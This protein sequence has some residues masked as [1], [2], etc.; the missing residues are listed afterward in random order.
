MR[1]NCLK[2][3][4]KAAVLLAAVLLL[5][6]GITAAQSV[7]L[8]AGPATATLPDGSAVPMWGYTCGAVVAP[9]TCSPLNPAS[10]GWSPVV[11]TVPTGTSLAINLTN[12]LS[13]AG[14]NIPTSLTIV[15][16]VGGGLGTGAVAV[17]SPEHPSQQTTWPLVNA[18]P[19]WIPPA[20]GPRVQSFA[21]EVAVGTPQTLTWTN[22]RPGT[23]LI[24]SGT[25]P[26][27][28]GPMGL[29]GILVVTQVPVGTTAGT[30]Y[31]AVGSTPAVNYNAE[32]PLL[33][34]EIDPA[35]NN[36]VNAA[37]KTVGFSEN[38]S[39][40]PQVSGVVLGVSVTNPGSGYTSA[41]NVTLVGGGGSG[42]TATA[43]IDAVLTSPTYGQVTSI[44]VTSGG[45]N[46]TSPPTVV[47]T[48]T[49]GG[50]GA[51]A[52]S[53]L[54][55]SSNSLASCMTQAGPVAA[56]YPPAVNYTPLYYMVNGVA[57]NKTIASAS[58]FPVSP[59]TGVALTGNVL[60]RMV[61][62][63]VRMHVP[64]IVGS[65]AQQ[66][67]TGT[68][69]TVGGFQLI[70]EDGN[71][72]PGIPRVQ[73][74]V[75]MAPGKTYDVKINV[76]AATA[77]A[78]PIYDRELSL[79]G[80]ATERDAGMLAYISVNG[81]GL[82]VPATA[83]AVANADTYN[84]L[85]AGQTFTVSDTGKG[86][87]AND[88]NVYAVQVKTPP[89]NGT[90]TL[91][92]NGTFT[93]VPTGTATTDSFVYEANG[94]PAIFATVTLGPA[95]IEAASGITVSANCTVPLTYTSKL[96]TFI[97]V[98]PPGILSCFND[99]AGYPL[100]A[101]SVTPG[102]GL[103][104]TTLNVDKNGGFSASVSGAGTYSFTFVPQNSQGT[105]AAAATTV[106]V[107]FPT[108]NGPTVQ[109]VD[110][111]SGAPITDYRWIIEEDRTFY[112]SPNC[113]SN[114][115][116][117]GCIQT[118]AGTVP[119]LG[120]NFHTSDMP[121]VAQGCTGT[122][123]CE[124]GQTLLGQPA[125]C[126]VGNGSC[127]TTGTQKAAVD[128]SQVALDPSKRYYISVLPGDAAQPFISGNQTASCLPA[129]GGVSPNCGHSMG[130]API[131]VACTPAVGSTTCTGTFP[132]VKVLVEQ[133]PFPPAKLAVNVFEDDFPL[134]GEQDSGGGIDVL[135]TNEP[136][137]GQFNILLWDDMGGS[138]DVTG[139]MTYDMF[140]MPLSNSLDGYIDPA[141]GQN[142]CPIS[143]AGQGI[144]GMIVTCP[145]FESDGVTL[146]PLAGE[147][148]IANLMP[149]RFSV[150]A[151]PGA[152]RIARGEEWL[153]TNTLDG[154]KAHDSFLRIGEPDYFQEFGPA[155]YHVNIGFANPKIINGRLAGVCAG[156]DQNLSL[157][158]GSSCN[159]TL[160][161]KV[162][163]ERMS[164]TPD[165]RLYSSGSRDS[166]YFTQCFVSVGDPDGED[167][168]FTKCAADGTFTL[169]G[170]PPG[171]WR[172][173]TFD[174]WNDQIVDGLSFPVG[175]NAGASGGGSNVGNG[176]CPGA[177]TSAN[178]C[179][180]GDVPA[181]QWQA[182][183][184]TKTFIDIPKTGV[185]NADVDEGI[186]FAS[187][188][189][190]YRDGSM[191]NNLTTDFTG[192]ANFNEE[193]PLFN[194][195]TV[196]TDVTRYKNTGIHTVYDSGGPAD[197]TTSCGQKTSGY[198]NCGT[199]T[200]YNFLANTNEPVPLPGDLSVPGAIYCTTADCAS[201]SIL[202]GAKPSRAGISTGRVD[203]PWVGVEGWQGYSGENNFIEFGKAP[204]T[205][206]ENGGIKGHVIYAS[207]RPF[208]DP[209]MLVQTQWEPL[210]PH[211]TMNLY[212]EGVA[213]DGITPTLTLVD[214]T[215]TSSW[216][217]FAQGYRTDVNG[218]LIPSTGPNG[219]YVPNMSCPG[220]STSD[221]FYFSLQNQPS[222]LDMYNNTL[223]GTGAA[224]TVMPY[225]SQYKCYD[226]LHNWNQLQ[227][228]PYDGMYSFPSITSRDAT[229]KPVGTNC[230]VCTTDP[231]T[232]LYHGIPM[233]PVG[234]YVVEVVPPQGYEIVKEEDKNI[235]IGDNFIAPV[236]QEFGAL[237]SIFIIPDQAQVGSAYNSYN[238][239]NPTQSLGASPNNGIVPAF[240]PEPT[241]PCVGEQ[242]IVP[243]YISLFPESHQVAPFAGATR[244]LCDRK[245]VTLTDQAGAIAKF[246]VY[247]STH[248]A[249][250]FTGVITDDFTSE[251]DPFSPQFGEKFAPPN[252]PI[253]I[254]DWTGT[255]INRVYSD[256]WGD[257]DGLTYSTWEV[258]PPNPTGYSPTMMIFCMNDKGTGT[259]ADPLFNPGYSQFCYELPYMPG[260]TQY[261]DTP[262]VP[263]SAFSAG[264][265][266]PDCNYP[267]A[268]PAV[269]EVD[270]DGKGPW[271]SVAGNPITITA[272]GDQ[273][274]INNAY[275]GPQAKSAPFNE[276]FVTRHY[277]FGAQCTTPT[278]GSATCNTLSTVT[279]GGV[280]ATITNWTDSSIT[281]TVPSGVP[282]CAVQQQAQYGG[283]LAQCGQL[284]ITAGS[285]QQSVDTVTVTIGGK[286][287]TYVTT[288]N[289]LTPYGTGS[290]QAAID[291][292]QPGDLIM[293]PP[294]DYQEMLLMWKPVRLQGAGAAST[295][296]DANAQPAGKM[297]PWRRQLVCLFGLALNGVPDGSLNPVTNTPYVFDPTGT[298]TC[299]STNGVPWN[300]FSGVN[301][302]P[303][304]DRI[305]LE[306]IVGWDTTTNG[307]L[308]QLLSEPTLMGAYEGAAVSIIAKG[309]NPG[310]GDY[311]GVANEA[312]FPT[313]TVNLT[314][315][316]CTTG[317]NGA[318][319]YP[320]NFQCNPS[321]IDGLSL[322]DASEGGGGIFVHAWAHNLQIANNRVFSNIG[323]LSGGINIGQGESPDAYLNG[324][325]LDTDPGSCESGA[326]DP[327]NTQEPYCFNLNV[328][329]HNNSVTSNTSIGDEL[330][331]GTP[332]G[333]GG[334]SF[335]TGAD[336]YKFN[337]NWVCGNMST[338][339]GGG[340]SHIGFI[341][342]GDIEHNTVLFNQS[343]N[344]T[345]PTNGGGIIVMTTA[346]D[347]TPPGAA[348]G[349]ECGSVTDVDCAP[350]LGDGT[351][352]GLV[353]NA[354]LVMGNAAEAG[355]GGGI[356]FQ[357]VNGTDIPRFPVNPENWYSV[358]VTNNI[359]TN[360]VAG[361][362]GG[363]VSLQDAVAVDLVNNTIASND[364]TATA[365]VLFNTLGAP[366][367]SA[368]GA[369]NQ[370]T[371]SQT[372]A[373]QAAGVVTMQ[374]SSGLIAAYAGVTLTCPAN[375]AGCAAFSNPYLA[376]DLIW[377]NRS[378]YVGVGATP[379][380]AYQQNIVTLYNAN[381]TNPT[382]GSNLV[383]QA[384]T[385]QCVTGSSY[386]DIGARG[387]TGPGNHGSGYTV[388]PTYSV[389]TNSSE[390][391]AGQHDTNSN[392]AF[393][394]QYCNGSRVPPE[395]ASGSFNVPPGISDAT[396]PNPLFN[397]TPA[398][399]VDEGNNWINMTWGPLA[400]ANPVTGVTLGN[401]AL[402]SGSPAI[403]YIPTSSPTYSTATW[404]TQA[405][406]FFGNKRPEAATATSFDIGA[407][408]Y[409]SAAVLPPT[410]TSI[411]PTSGV[412]GATVAVTLTGTNLTGTTAVNVSGA[413]GSVTV[414]GITVVNSTTVTATFTISATAALTARTVTVTTAG[415]TSNAET[416]TVALPTLTSIAPVSGLRGTSVPV[417]LTGTG[418]TG[419]TSV[420]VSGG[421]ITVS[422]VTVVNDTTVT[423]T[424][425]IA[426][427]ATAS[428]R[429][430]A[431][432][433]TGGTTGNV[434]FTVIAPTLTSIAPVSG[435]RG[436]SVPV[437]LT[438]VGLT[439]AT[440]VTVSG[441]A[442][443]VTVSGMTVVNDTTITATFAISA[444]AALTARNVAVVTPGGTTG[445]VTFTVL[446]PPLPTLSSIA[447]NTGVRGASVPV[448][449][450]GVNLTGASAVNVSGT[451]ITVSGIT[452][453]NDTTVTATFAIT[454][455]ATLSSRNVSV[456]TPGGTSN[457]VAFTVQGA[458][459]TSIAPNTGA[460]G[461][462]VPVTLAGTNLTGAT[463]VAV[464]GGGVTVS[465]F[466]AVNSTT[467]TA[468]FTITAG[469]ALTARNVTVTTPIG[470]TAAVTF[471]VVAPPAPT[472]AS[473]SPVSGLHA[474]TVPVT[475]TGTNFTATGTTVA[476][477]GGGVTVSGLTVVN[478]TTVTANFVITNGAARTA[479]NVTV[480]TPG[481][482]TGA[483]TFTVN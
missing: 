376:N 335:C 56:C 171:D 42:A 189:V 399:T 302:N 279:I 364:S 469:A 268:T 216:D 445:N 94:N 144:T 425:A 456:T 200:A 323:T 375:H 387:D 126:D 222:Y 53:D 462:S 153:Q 185:F 475:L 199:S 178:T 373:P 412:R 125:V 3:N 471:T 311:F 298:Y 102:P 241:W 51:A 177:A 409:Q 75:F 447:P 248:K 239:Q 86:V 80:N 108:G 219:G 225:Q 442:G 158:P 183:V 165:E 264:Y 349:T 10:A 426:A 256:W 474:T 431:V 446:A 262:V 391:P 169:T 320:S 341:K 388:A 138:G 299:G 317:S 45:I 483:V 223:H 83:T 424:F 472:L 24:E 28:Q 480:T 226:G 213:A 97:K 326:G 123:S 253:A 55:R 156:T 403:D 453:V 407:I 113:T 357:G 355:S 273:Q 305:P 371:S 176:T 458:T 54:S 330:F 35:Q 280:P 143:A 193:F 230:K 32:I 197:G 31:P 365:G 128:P 395:F 286:A 242:R 62:A 137:L 352:P 301:N 432:V 190:R 173:T 459:L 192:T 221:L 246:Y 404:P 443:S 150:Q 8:T 250:K 161:G 410:L 22:P 422:G 342:N 124:S 401:Y 411:A 259:T 19:T 41:P 460:E 61:N 149:G 292:A 276:Q 157:P 92:A 457:T 107:T 448:T 217:D 76:P 367:A 38:A 87:I 29:D 231:A 435:V 314:A 195:Y 332:A 71:P 434:T 381:F 96:A 334:V 152:D 285:G 479:R 374:N 12:N 20:Q 419:A 266:H 18:G 4:M 72:L 187:V 240:I 272:L 315:A 393:T 204:Y 148:V 73:S 270:G 327:V 464:S 421:N 329:V 218:N 309:V 324:T 451:G 394:S 312:T 408:E 287:P 383:N 288:N 444:T 307:N 293:I 415:G 15:G 339:D 310:P 114:P 164:R 65:T 267:A 463:S 13:F 236:T 27:I 271:V 477:A 37:V 402:N 115:P 6:A 473:I 427:G 121:Y 439:G 34:S 85:V 416:F 202:N 70:A 313:G 9:A 438:G 351:G 167:F 316:D 68:G 429:N 16:Q 449:L 461:T 77:K 382:Q 269:S 133:D 465:N 303:Q 60:V 180:M 389:L 43:N 441:A 338:G 358:K 166:F 476:V 243:D 154:Q 131:P 386:W 21:T 179:D 366:L 384:T 454:T 39:R 392:P 1:F 363:G 50:S 160:T 175:L 237:S 170:L 257:Y 283:S 116:P 151:I 100:T 306:G 105:S 244:N 428:A 163:T 398:A 466:V 162:T 74:E 406:D 57:F 220:Q 235:L 452:V 481:G 208:D 260:Q 129:V 59:A 468:T 132:A 433:T 252:M 168:A 205:V 48:P 64:S 99:A 106:M 372:S 380:S 282:N 291:A 263:T 109:V 348:A 14:G 194:W 227:P 336:Y 318:N 297:D 345:I 36:A 385:G 430:V 247:T 46:Y 186:P 104:A 40:G 135:A 255:E 141:T 58:L 214:T 93:Y 139:Q 130:G 215:Q 455:G 191:S 356:R 482:T 88:I 284:V 325:T 120:T 159:N 254:K 278:S 119:L 362:D 25:H 145:K 81:A 122:L 52:V 251:F 300:G 420:T 378:Y 450:T 414:S 331:S 275:S 17:A 413:A 136:G 111:K 140:N 322:T 274:V 417:T 281:A 26:S 184:Y 294:G 101:T 289:P 182:N 11:I 359:V 277:G 211:V 347:G 89:A 84:S 390:T 181:N 103:S 82:P 203:P 134:N 360:N 344:P 377:Q 423:A 90:L 361:W 436:A 63:G 321:S 369:T 44:T 33:L 478:A 146:S 328:N 405:L 112:I 67:A 69:V 7:S 229:G 397:L 337:Y 353:I 118:A 238:A 258:N 249:A 261:L 155:N 400:E 23:Y 95:S 290:I 117:A 142:A 212:Q 207:T 418:L 224:P 91:N 206:G 201:E 228:A 209:Y 437:T 30:A 440:A 333:A 198:P 110:G 98:P 66:L 354:N 350:G 370:T 78:L 319:P 296:I 232:D 5:G 79:S 467:V 265:N 233:L 304:V 127:R 470:T 343:L 147:A 188:S 396:V 234:K 49:A 196:E 210:V 295:T 379:S 2:A 346:P 47:F 308:A 340:L 368:P 172:V 245:E 174:Q